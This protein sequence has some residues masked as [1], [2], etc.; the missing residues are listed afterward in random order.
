M[1]IPFVGF[2]AIHSSEHMASHGIFILLQVYM[3]V[4]FIRQY[5]GE[6][7]FKFLSRI[8]ITGT[9]VMLF[10]AFF[11]MFIT[12]RTKWSGRSMTLLD[13]TYAKKYIPI[14]ASVSEHQATTW[15]SYFFDLHYLMVF[16]PVGL[17]YCFKKPNYGKIFIGIY[18]VLSVYFAS[19]MIRLL[20][21]MAPAA[22]IAGGIGVSHTMRFLTKSIRISLL[23][24]DKEKRGKK[25]KTRLPAVIAIMGL[26][27][28]A[29]FISTYVLHSN[30]TGAEAYASPSIIMSSKDR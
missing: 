28:L 25:P 22:C 18:V 26:L 29:S 13:P 30:F 11:F 5:I 1:Q 7:G 15:S 20:L 21:V 9:V 24:E 6:A 2:Q 8:F 27:M 23:G 16:S 10:L 14:I 4:G 19:V 17:W 3:F 12:G